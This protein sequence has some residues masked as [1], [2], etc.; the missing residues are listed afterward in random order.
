MANYGQYCPLAKA[1]ELIG[2]RW[3]LLIIRELLYGPI[4]FGE[5]ERNLPGISKSVLSQRLKRLKHD[6]IA[7]TDTD[8]AYEFTEIGETLRPVVQT[9]GE[10][11]ATYVLEEPTRAEA[12]PE[13]LMLFVS[14]HV[15]VDRIPKRR[16]VTEWRFRD[17]N[18]RIWLTIEEN[19]VSVCLEDPCLDVDVYVEGDTIDL[20]RVYVGRTSLREA[21]RSGT[22][23]LRGTRA[24][25]AAFHG[26]M[27]WSSFSPLAKPS[28]QTAPTPTRLQEI[29]A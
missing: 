9:M 26:L 5:I 17:C 29:R 21:I 28:L 16:V 22:I 13:L 11:V 10:W 23:V 1:A 27:T 2:D 12:D 4:R 20:Y 25:V 24:M 19:D 6:G 18:R 15:D 8:G 14:R 7:R 3:T